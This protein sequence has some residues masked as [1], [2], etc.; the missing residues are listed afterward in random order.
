MNFSSTLYNFVL[1]RDSKGLALF[2]GCSLLPR[3]AFFLLLIC[4][5]LSVQF[6]SEVFQA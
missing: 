6:R 5:N 3:Q 4:I 1:F 2:F